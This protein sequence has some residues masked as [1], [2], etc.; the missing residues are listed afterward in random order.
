M[1]REREILGIPLCSS[2]EWILLFLK[3][4]RNQTTYFRPS[5]FSAQ[6]FF[7]SCVQ[8]SRYRVSAAPLP[9]ATRKHGHFLR[10]VIMLCYPESGK[11]QRQITFVAFCLPFG[12]HASVYRCV[13]VFCGA[14]TLVF[15]R[16]GGVKS[17][18]LPCCTSANNTLPLPPSALCWHPAL[19]GKSTQMLITCY[20]HLYL[21][22]PRYFKIYSHTC[23]EAA[24]PRWL[25]L[26]H[27]ELIPTQRPNIVTV[28]NTNVKGKSVSFIH[29]CMI[30]VPKCVFVQEYA[31]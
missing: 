25:T 28:L 16:V 22:W 13:Q 2:K 4:R 15:P 1:K 31:S 29:S 24:V 26:T 6:L 12:C 30:S 11:V 23:G 20:Q 3:I 18:F 14:F 19:F 17:N 8:T 21:Q 9:G 5:S 10:E 27:F 7:F